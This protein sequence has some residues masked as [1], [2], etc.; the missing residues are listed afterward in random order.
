V[1]APPPAAANEEQLMALQALVQQGLMEIGEN[2]AVIQAR[3][4]GTGRN[5]TALRN[6][7]KFIENKKQQMEVKP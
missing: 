4:R 5:E 2:E 1:P 6:L 3:L 7:L